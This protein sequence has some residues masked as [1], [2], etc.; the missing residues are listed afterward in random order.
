MPDLIRVVRDLFTRIPFNK[1]LGLEIDELTHDHARVS[2]SMRDELVGNFTRNVLHGG[3]TAATLDVTGGLMAFLG[4]A[5]HVRTASLEEK[6][7]RFSRIGTID[8][9]VD[10]LRP[11]IGTAFVATARI[12][13]TGNQITVVHTELR[14]DSDELVA[15]GTC[16]YFVG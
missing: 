12:V 11:G 9:R 5:K 16:T 8:M 7:A 1:L 14:D 10:Y 6:M 4:V 15:V 13:R 2:F 3:V